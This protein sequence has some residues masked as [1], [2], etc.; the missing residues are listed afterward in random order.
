[1]KTVRV[2]TEISWALLGMGGGGFSDGIV[3]ATYAS[4]TQGSGETVTISA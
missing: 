1:M 4:G 3:Y 2:L